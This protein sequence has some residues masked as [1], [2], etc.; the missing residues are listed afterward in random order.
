MIA[1]FSP[2]PRGLIA[3]LDINVGITSVTVS[4]CERNIQARPNVKLTLLIFYIRGDI[5]R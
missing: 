4:A 1:F 3:S 2:L 5:Y